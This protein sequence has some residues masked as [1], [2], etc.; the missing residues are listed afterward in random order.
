MANKYGKGYY[1]DWYEMINGIQKGCEKA[2]RKACLELCD[3]AND[4]IRSGIYEKGEIQGTYDQTL[5][6]SN[7]D[8]L[9]ADISGLECQ[10]LYNNQEFA[11]LS[12]DSVGNHVSDSYN[13]A[14]HALSSDSGNGYDTQ[15]FMDEIISPIHDD[16]MVDVRYY[17]QEEFP[18]IYRKY[19]KEEKFILT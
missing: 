15:K 11:T 5:E 7:I 16:F 10:F 13:M 2:F 17:I 6:M 19:C 9:T 3:K 4:L 14:H 18:K 1:S 8:Y 12:I